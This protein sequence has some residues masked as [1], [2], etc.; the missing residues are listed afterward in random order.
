MDIGGSFFLLKD[1]CSW[2]KYANLTALIKTVLILQ[3]KSD[4]ERGF[5]ID[6]AM[7]R[8]VKIN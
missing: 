8:L 4:P 7:V 3:G 6:T 2:L 5:S 1:N